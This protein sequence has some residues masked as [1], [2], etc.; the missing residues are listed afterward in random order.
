MFRLYLISRVCCRAHRIYSL[1][2]VVHARSFVWDLLR[3]CDR[4]VAGW[5]L[6]WGR[7]CRTWTMMLVDLL[8]LLFIVK[9]LSVFNYLWNYKIRDLLCYIQ[10]TINR[11]F[12]KTLKLTKTMTEAQLQWRK[13]YTFL[14]L[15]KCC[16][17]ICIEIP[18]WSMT[19]V[20]S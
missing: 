9:V 15:T 18:S 10:G 17:Y 7:T 2:M 5:W 3:K 14:N 11:W 6:S 12:D 8:S 16:T 20:H 13:I 19:V 1:R 4:C